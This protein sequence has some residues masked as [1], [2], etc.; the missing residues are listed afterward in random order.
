[1]LYSLAMIRT[2]HYP[3]PT[4]D[5]PELASVYEHFKVYTD[6]ELAKYIDRSKAQRGNP[7]GITKEKKDAATLLGNDDTLAPVADIIYEKKD[8]TVH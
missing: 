4:R 5:T 7:G 8:S 2:E 1:M 3:R 6:N